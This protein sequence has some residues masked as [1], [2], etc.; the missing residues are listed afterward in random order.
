MNARQKEFANK[1]DDVTIS[2]NQIKKG[3]L[4]ALVINFIN[5]VNSGELGLPLRFYV[6]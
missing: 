5:S 2:G 4:E 1:R 6:G 3:A